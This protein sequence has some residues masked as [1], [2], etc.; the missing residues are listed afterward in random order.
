M[1]RINNNV[2]QQV[3]AGIEYASKIAKKWVTIV[4][5]YAWGWS[6]EE[7]FCKYAPEYGMGVLAKIRVPLGTKDFMPYLA[8][9]PKG[10][11]GVFYAFFFAEYLALVRDLKAVRPD[12]KHYAPICAP[13]GI[14]TAEIAD[15]IE[16][17]HYLAWFPRTVKEFDTPYIRALRREVGIDDW[18]KEVGTG[19]MLTLSHSWSLWEAMFV[20]KKAIEATGWK[21]KGDNPKL[22]EYLEGL[23]LKESEWF[24]QGDKFIRAQDHQAFIR[25]MIVRVVGGKFELVEMVPIE[26]SIYPPEVDFTKEPF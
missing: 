23:E 9:I 10:A 25:H 12:L 11:E 1:F 26:K 7:E 19:R 18:G 15:L 3:M 5:D 24:P 13:E 21:D 8:K 14:D 16:G 20:I 22:I 6:N 2:R 17:A 4:A